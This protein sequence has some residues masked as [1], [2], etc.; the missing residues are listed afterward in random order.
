MAQGFMTLFGFFVI[1]SPALLAGAL[2][3]VCG[4]IGAKRRVNSENTAEA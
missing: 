2:G 3:A 1:I 4:M